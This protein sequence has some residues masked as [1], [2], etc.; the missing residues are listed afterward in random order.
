MPGPFES[1]AKSFDVKSLT[2]LPS[3]SHT[4]LVTEVARH[5]RPAPY[6]RRMGDIIAAGLPHVYNGL[7]LRLEKDANYVWRVGGLEVRKHLG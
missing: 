2:Q 7:H 1:Q 3:R 5:L 4:A 6:L